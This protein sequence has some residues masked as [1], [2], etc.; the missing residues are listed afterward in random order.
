[1]DKSTRNLD[2]REQEDKAKLNWLRAAA[3]GGFEAGDRG[4]YVALNSGDELDALLDHRN[5]PLEF[6]PHDLRLREAPTKGTGDD[7]D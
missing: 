2:H 3:K 5:A 6:D 4:D 7:I 1:M